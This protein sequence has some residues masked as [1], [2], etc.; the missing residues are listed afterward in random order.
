MARTAEGARLTDQHRRAQAALSAQATR[1]ARSQF[2]R[3]DPSALDASTPEWM[4]AMLGITETLSADAQRI[5]AEY[6]SRHAQA[7][8]G[9]GLT[10]VVTSPDMERI[11]TDYR[12]NGPIA[13]KTHIHNGRTVDEAMAIVFRDITARLGQEVINA[14]RN[15]IND[16]V[17][18]HGRGGRVRRVCGHDACAFCAMLVGRGPVYTEETGT[19]RSHNHCACTWEIVYGMWVPTEREALWRA[20]YTRAA[21]DADEFDG[22]RT[23]PAPHSDAEDTILWRMRR[24]APE[25]FTDGVYPRP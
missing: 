17:Y 11:I 15:L 2:F 16:Q 22:V 4:G 13:V 10:P 6:V 8:T 21:L 18:Y 14:G 3:L 24:N 20:S 25:L 1:L 5:A 9:H 12:V 7:E 23:A 19:F